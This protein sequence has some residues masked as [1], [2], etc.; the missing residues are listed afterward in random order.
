MIQ[1]GPEVLAGPEMAGWIGE[2]LWAS[3]WSGD[4]LPSA[5]RIATQ[6]GADVAE[7]EARVFVRL[8][9]L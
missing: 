8:C 4:R 5:R 7:A 6:A 2:A 3:P 9:L 1:A